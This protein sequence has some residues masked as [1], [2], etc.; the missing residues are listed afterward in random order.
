MYL[1]PLSTNAVGPALVCL[2]NHSLAM[3]VLENK[4]SLL[5]SSFTPQPLIS[6]KKANLSAD[7]RSSSAGRPPP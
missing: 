1:C 2:F 7:G 4:A 5:P 3:A 6:K